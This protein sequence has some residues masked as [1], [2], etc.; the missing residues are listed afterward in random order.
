MGVLI[1][2]LNQRIA[3]GLKNGKSVG[4]PAK[5]RLE[6]DDEELDC[7]DVRNKEKARQIATI[8]GR[9]ARKSAKPEGEKKTAK[10]SETKSSANKR[11]TETG[12]EDMK[13]SYGDMETG[14]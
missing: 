10:N 3:V 6:I 5:E 11:E 8:K 12:D 14:D 9:P 4:L 1:N 2:K 13:K 7:D